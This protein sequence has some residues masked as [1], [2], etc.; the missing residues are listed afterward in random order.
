MHFGA[1]ILLSRYVSFSPNFRTLTVRV[2]IALSC[3]KNMYPVLLVFTW[4]PMPPAICSR[5]CSKDSDWAGEFSWSTRSSAS[6][7][8]VIVSEGYR[9][10]LTFFF[11]LKP[12]PFISSI[13]IRG[14]LS[15]QIINKYGANVS[16]CNTPATM[17]KK[18][19]SP[20]DERNIALCFY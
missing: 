17:S 11:S 9:R 5:L 6:S 13:Y 8:S 12:S 7:G 4:R 1:F 3:L 18:S 16:P 20:S 2:K 10:L 19:V 15:W 14:T